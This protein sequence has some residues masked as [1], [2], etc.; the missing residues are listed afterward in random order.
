LH[1]GTTTQVIVEFPPGMRL[2][3]LE[4]SWEIGDRVR[5]GRHP[6]HA[7]TLR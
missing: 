6:D 2:V 1:V 5:L 3:A 7:S 4:Q